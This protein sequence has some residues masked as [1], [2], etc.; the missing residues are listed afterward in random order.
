[1]VRL[2][3]RHRPDSSLATPLPYVVAGQRVSEPARYQHDNRMDSVA[4]KCLV[5]RSAHELASLPTTSSANAR[6]DAVCV[7]RPPQQLFHRLKPY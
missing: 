4:S 1:M 7:V 3:E 2:L 5:R 6:C